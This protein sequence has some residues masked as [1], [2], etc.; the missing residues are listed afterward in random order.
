MAAL[1]GVGV[2]RPCEAVL[3][4]DETLR[5]VDL[6]GLAGG[7]R[8]RGGQIE[9]RFSATR[10]GEITPPLVVGP[11]ASRLQ[12]SEVELDLPTGPDIKAAMLLSGLYADGP[13]Y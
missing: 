8:R 3:S 11:L 2:A 9:G 5:A 12:L 13:T 7:L 10:P 4:G 1:A 6:S